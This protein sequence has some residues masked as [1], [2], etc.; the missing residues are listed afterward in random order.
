MSGTATHTRTNTD[1]DG[2][3][4]GVT[5][6]LALSSVG[7]QEIGEKP[8]TILLPRA[9]ELRVIDP[10]ALQDEPSRSRGTV[11]PATVEGLVAYCKAHDEGGTEV[12]ITP[13][14]IVAV[15][16]AQASDAKDVGWG[17]HRAV[18]DLAKSP[19]WLHWARYDG[20]MLDQATLA[21]HIEDGQLD[22][23]TPESATMLEVV[24][25][26]QVARAA[27]FRSSQRLNSGTIGF[28]YDETDEAKAGQNGTLEI[29]TEFELG[30]PVFLGE[31]AYKVVCRFRYRLKEGALTVGYKIDRPD[32]IEQD[33]ANLIAARL[34]GDDADA[35]AE[36]PP[37]AEV[38]DGAPAEPVKAGL[39]DLR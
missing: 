34:R 10:E 39:L 23:V 18:L 5:A 3:E 25:D 16:N 11:K 7:H 29:P 31:D 17:D 4:H 6:D 14:R 15:L 1:D 21:E 37:F 27:S 30:I 24:Q 8:V 22:I 2:T 26:L 33:A 32:L 36:K 35:E 9:S 19:Q 28:I 12:W 13:E 20:Q 38:F